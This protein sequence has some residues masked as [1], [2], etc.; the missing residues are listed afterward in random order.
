M[1]WAMRKKAILE[2]LFTAVM[3]LF[4]GV[5]TKVKVGT[6]FCEEFEVSIGVP[7]GSV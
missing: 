1:A 5:R 7:Q 3:S 6:H 2:A 4:I